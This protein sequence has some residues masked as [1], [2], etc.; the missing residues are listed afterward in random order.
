LNPG[1]FRQKVLYLVVHA[2]DDVRGHQAVTHALAGIRPGT[3]RR[4]DRTGL[5]TNQHGDV[6]A[7]GN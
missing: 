7:S 4:I 5:A 1:S 2:G 6:A 3:H